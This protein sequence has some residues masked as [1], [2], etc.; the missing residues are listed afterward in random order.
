MSQKS[1]GKIR[2]T[3]CQKTGFG[4]SV[5]VLS[6]GKTVSP[7]SN[8]NFFFFFFLLTDGERPLKYISEKNRGFLE[9][10]ALMPNQANALQPRNPASPSPPLPLLFP[11]ASGQIQATLGV[12]AL[13]D[14]GRRYKVKSAG[15][16][17]SIKARSRLVFCRCGAAFVSSLREGSAGS[18]LVSSEGWEKEKKQGELLFMV[19]TASKAK[20]K[21]LH[22][23]CFQLLLCCMKP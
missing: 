13:R 6:R 12:N 8:I 17:T 5:E 16:Q 3:K 10:P 14:R 18:W 7:N 15:R 21:T 9:K 23:W 11:A 22:N 4:I 1:H 20:K 19:Q 2:I